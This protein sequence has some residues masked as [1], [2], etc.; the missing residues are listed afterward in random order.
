MDFLSEYKDPKCKYCG[1]KKSDH[2]AK[3]ANC[4]IGSKHKSVGYTSYH[5]SQTFKSKK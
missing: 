3:T 1:K 2:L 5:K 4:P